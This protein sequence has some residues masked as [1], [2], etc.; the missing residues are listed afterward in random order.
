MTE[1]WHRTRD[2]VGLPG[3][4]KERSIRLHGA[5]RGWASRPISG[6]RRGSLEWLES[7]LPPATQDALRLARGEAPCPAGAAEGGVSTSVQAEGSPSAV[8]LP[9]G[10]RGLR[11]D[12]R[13]EIV[14]AF[15][16]WRAGRLDLAL[17]PAL[18]AWVALYA[19]TGDGVSAETRK[20]YSS[21]AWNTLQR[22]RA[23]WL[24]GGA[25]ALL[26]DCGGNVSGIDADPEIRAYIEGLLLA[27][28]RHITARHIR[29]ATAARFPDRQA[30]SI[31]TI[32]RWVRRYRAE[33]G[34]ALSAVSDPDGHRSGYL[35]A[36]GSMTDEVAEL[37]QLWELDSTRLDVM[38]SDGKRYSVAVAIDVWSRRG[39]ALVCPESRSTAIAAL[40]R[41]CLIAW[42]APLEVRTDEGADYTSKHIR[43]VLADLKVLHI[44]CPPYSPDKKPFVERVIGT[45]ARDCLANL[46]G[47]TGHDVADREK[48]RSRKSFAARRGEDPVLTFGC[49]LTP[50]QLQKHLDDWFEFAYGREE[51]SGLGR[52]SPFE[53]AASWAGERRPVDERGLDVLLAPAAGRDGW[54]T[55]NK[56]GIA[57]DGGL[58]IAAELGLY[59]RERVQ[60]R[61]TPADYGRIFVFD[62]DGRFVCI[63]EDPLRTGIDREQVAVTAK[64]LAKE[65]TRRARKKARDLARAAEPLAAMG[66][67][68]EHA[69]AEAETLVEFRPRAEPYRTDR[70]DAAAEAEDAAAEAD[71]PERRRTGTGTTIDNFKKFYGERRHD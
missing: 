3:M 49:D 25:I 47:F 58:Y 19:E 70:M 35:P 22:W 71:A 10:K 16:R 68:L 61:Q 1:R 32:R 67:A 50:E 31:S 38:C 34:F 51:H 26:P 24:K 52:M 29:R 56:N 59:M 2:L 17:V 18:K 65:E 5:R 20:E 55:V 53:K 62:A 21:L 23:A 64:R 63:A 42:G 12:A 41:R 28:P 4:P 11:A 40:I 6:D 15:E 43:R 14:S 7:S 46:P 27:N 9:V 66:M 44:V 36:F 69:A 13:T 30:P 60:V 37:N 33:N 54:R 8:S 48:I 39:M 45:M 57:V